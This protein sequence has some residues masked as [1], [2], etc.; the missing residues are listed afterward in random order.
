[1][2]IDKS[3]F[4]KLLEFVTL[5]PHYFVGSNADLPIVGGSILAH[6]HFQGGRYTFA[7]ASAPIEETYTIPN[8]EDVEVGRVKWPMS[9]LRLRSY[10]YERLVELGDRILTKWRG[11][12]AF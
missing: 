9:V 6:E 5:F 11:Y 2:K 7:M 3:A 4:S 10:D 12:C 1:M 8:F